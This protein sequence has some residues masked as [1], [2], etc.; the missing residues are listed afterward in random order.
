MSAVFIA[1]EEDGHVQGIGVD[2]LMDTGKMD[3]IKRGPV[4]W[5]DVADSQPCMGTAG[6]VTWHLK[7]TGKLFHSGLTISTPRLSPP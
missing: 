4:F 3:H 1:N 7:A 5:V 6:S 2:K